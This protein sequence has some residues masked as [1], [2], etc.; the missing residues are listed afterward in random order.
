V[1]DIPRL[2]RR[3]RWDGK[4]R[5]RLAELERKWRERRDQFIRSIREQLGGDACIETNRVGKKTSP[6]T[7]SGDRLGG[8][9]IVAG[10]NN[11]PVTNE[12]APMRIRILQAPLGDN[13]DGI[14]LSHFHVGNEYDVGATFAALFVAE[15]WAEPIPVSAPRVPTPF[16][17][18]DPFTTSV[19]DRSTPP[20][21]IKEQFPT[22]VGRDKAADARRRRR[23]HR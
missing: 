14:D 15:G 16:G 20:K 23:K 17:P 12:V 9:G 11:A 2:E 13:V 5:E 6:K 8:Q 4:A 21:L 7:G 10:I 22:Y 18:D 19:L 3:R 1:A